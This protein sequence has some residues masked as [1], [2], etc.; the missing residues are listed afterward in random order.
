MH[1]PLRTRSAHTLTTAPAPLTPT[2]KHTY[3]AKQV[4]V[5]SVRQQ[6]ELW[7]RERKESASY[8]QSQAEYLTSLRAPAATLSTSTTSQVTPGASVRAT[9]RIVAVSFLGG[10]H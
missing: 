6:L 8:L 5:S 3:A 9:D 10:M 1:V 4:D 2:P 7:Q